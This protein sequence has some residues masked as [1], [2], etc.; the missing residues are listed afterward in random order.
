[1]RTLSLVALL[2]AVVLVPGTAQTGRNPFLG[3]WDLVVKP[4]NNRPSFPDWMEVVERDGGMQ[5]RVQPSGGAVRPFSPVRMDGAKLIVTMS[6]AT[7][8]RPA[9]V[10][11]LTVEGDKIAG[12]QKSGDNT[13][14]ELAGVRAPALKREAPK[15]WTA[16]EPLFNGKDLTGW[17]PFNPATSR[18]VAKDGQL[19]N[20]DR[21]SN[22]KTTRKFDDFKLHIEVNCP[23]HGDN[24]LCNSGIYLRGRYEIQVGT[25]GGSTPKNE[26]GSVYGMVAPSVDMPLNLGQWQSL[27]ITLVGRYVT[28]V[29][30]GVTIHDNAEIPGFTGGALD[31]DEGQPGPFYIQGDHGPVEYRNITIAVPRR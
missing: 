10:W 11:E 2:A 30:N 6:Q 17:E 18:W 28:V 9:T 8:N 14:A 20:E 27:D 4:Q 31:A 25:E 26:M 16:P 23:P 12:V 7:A 5:A 24:K 3:R 13:T 21:G 22:I 15:A 19:L 29:R 1:M